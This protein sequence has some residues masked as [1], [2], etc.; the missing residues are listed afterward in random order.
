[1]MMMMMTG[2]CN[3]D[4]E[5]EHGTGRQQEAMFDERRDHPDVAVD[6]PH[7]RADGPGS[8]VAGDCLS[9]RHDLHGANNA[10]LAAGISVVDQQTSAWFQRPIQ[11]AA[12]RHVREVRRPVHQPAAQAPERT[13][14]DV[15]HEPRRQSDEHLRVPDRRLRE[16]RD[17]GQHLDERHDHVGRKRLLLWARVVH[18]RHR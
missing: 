12:Q 10:R 1:M 3:L 8:C 11:A 9:L 7:L 16:P 18:L 5:H 2:G 13:V 17:T 14:A 15:R 4:R 6:E